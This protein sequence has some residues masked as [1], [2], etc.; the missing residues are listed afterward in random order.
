M[1][2][3]PV[4]MGDIFHRLCFRYKHNVSEDGSASTIS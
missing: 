3:K 4:N 2:I 1:P